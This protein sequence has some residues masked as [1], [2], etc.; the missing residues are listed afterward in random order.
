MVAG[1]IWRPMDCLLIV[2]V[3]VKKNSPR[4]ID[5]YRPIAVF[6]IPDVDEINTEESVVDKTRPSSQSWRQQGHPLL[7]ELVSYVTEPAWLST[8]SM[9]MIFCSRSVGSSTDEYSPIFQTR[10]AAIT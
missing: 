7:P 9:G 8:Q 4:F 2:H 5:C 1:A 3:L 10:D 6:R